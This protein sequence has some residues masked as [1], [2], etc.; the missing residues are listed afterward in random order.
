MIPLKGINIAGHRIRFAVASGALGFDGLGWPWEQP[1]RWLGQL[2]PMAFD[3][4]VLKTLTS[5]PRAGNVGRWGGPGLWRTVKLLPGGAVNAVG[6]RNPGLSN[7]LI[8]IAPHIP[9]DLAIVIS[10][11][12]DSVQ[13]LNVMAATI[14]HARQYGSL[15]NKNVRA[16]ELNVSCP[17]VS[18]GDWTRNIGEVEEA[19]ENLLESTNLPVI[20]KLGY[21]PLDHYLKVAKI[22]APLVAAFAINSVPWRFWSEGLSP[23]DR[24]GG[25]GVSGRIVQDIT[26]QMVK[27]LAEHGPVF[28]PS[29]WTYDDLQRVVDC[30]AAAV[31]FGSI[32]LAHPTRPNAIMVR[33]Q[34]ELT[35]S[36]LRS[37]LTANR[38][39]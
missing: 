11:A 39:V 34:E 3:A 16:L 2:D 13:D 32:F 20:A 4:V 12:A 9:A 1:L 22:I 17:N 6:L 25:G 35:A 29:V 21:D 31:S 5:Q 38:S 24:F 26:W 36:T 15:Q 33:Y 37:T 19:V 27:N 28:G 7:W 18:H 30:G 10:L 8:K 23:L 14:R